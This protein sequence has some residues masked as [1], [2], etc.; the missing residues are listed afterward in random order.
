M[1]VY[2]VEQKHVQRV[3]DVSLVHESLKTQYYLLCFGFCLV[4]FIFVQEKYLSFPFLFLKFLVYFFLQAVWCFLLLRYGLGLLR[5]NWLVDLMHLLLTW[6]G[7]CGWVS[8]NHFTWVSTDHIGEGIFSFFPEIEF[9]LIR[10]QIL[11]VEVLQFR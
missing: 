1:R 7:C 10:V 6:L 9:L 4:Q 5:G 11:E 3:Y 8:L 2:T